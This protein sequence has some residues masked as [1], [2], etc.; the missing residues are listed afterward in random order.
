MTVQMNHNNSAA[1]MELLLEQQFYAS[2]N[3]L[4]TRKQIVSL[5]QVSRC[6]KNVQRK[7]KDLGVDAGKVNTTRLK[8][9]I[10]STLSQISRHSQ[11]RDI[12]LVL[13][14]DIGD[15]IKLAN[16]LDADAEAVH[17]ARAARIV[18]KDILKHDQFFKGTFGSECHD[19]SIPLSLKALVTFILKGSNSS[20]QT[21]NKETE[22][23]IYG[24][25]ASRSILQLLIVYNTVVRQ[26]KKP[27]AT[28]RHPRN[29]ETPL[30]IY[31]ALKIHGL[32]RGR[33]LN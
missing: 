17:L 18:R 10:L 13:D 8:D 32:T 30:P 15:A 25:Q 5:S 6:K 3:Y 33:N 1:C 9:R 12:L 22:Q 16:E 2:K 4:K 27:L 19:D 29:R 23:D 14:Q 26:T 11:G 31:V 28:A 7:L 24:N 20:R 21:V